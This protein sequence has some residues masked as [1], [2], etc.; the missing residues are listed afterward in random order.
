[1]YAMLN[2]GGGGVGAG[3]R[4]KKKHRKPCL[5]SLGSCFRTKKKEWKA[6]EARPP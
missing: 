2:Q 3:N 4:K 6:T 1:V 5:R